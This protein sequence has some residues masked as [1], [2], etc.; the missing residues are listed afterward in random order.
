[1][2]ANSL[3]LHG[4]RTLTGLAAVIFLLKSLNY[5]SV[6]MAE[7]CYHVKKRSERAASKSCDKEESKVFVHDKNNAHSFLN[8][9]LHFQS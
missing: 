4:H 8:R 1:M 3:Q 2:G 7:T 5:K 6:N 9:Q